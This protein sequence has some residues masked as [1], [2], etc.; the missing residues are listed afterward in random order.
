MKIAY[1]ITK[2]EIGGAQVHVL[3]LAK[4]MKEQ[5]HESAI[6][7]GGGGWLQREAE[8]IGITFYSNPYFANSFN[9]FRILQSF[10]VVRKLL[11]IFGPD[12]VHCHSSFA[13]VIGRVVVRSKIPTVFTAHSWAFTDGAS[14]FRK[15]IAPFSE[16]IVSQWTQKII[17]VSEYDRQLAIRYRIAPMEKLIVIHN[18]VADANIKVVREQKIISIGRLAYPKEFKLLLQAYKESG[19]SMALEIIGDG[20]DKAMIKSEISRLDLRDVVAIRDNLE[21]PEAVRV[22]L[23]KAEVF[24]LIS[25]HEGLPMTILEAMAAGLPVIASRVGGIPEEIDT[26]CGVLVANKK[27]SIAQAIRDLS[28][29]HMQRQMGNA[30]RKRFEDHFTVEK[31]LAETKKVYDEVCLLHQ[32]S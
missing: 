13:G 27:E 29:E 8:K 5:G 20:P 17:C 32:T 19:V 12:I 16:R 15:I 4:Y 6:I 18:G 23:A 21:G 31:F 11:K 3:Q 14:V 25:K 22:E 2:S 30:S 26:A 1:L 24:I 28:D 10:F 7:A 9:P